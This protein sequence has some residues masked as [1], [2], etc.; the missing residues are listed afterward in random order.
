MSYLKGARIPF[1]TKYGESLAITN[2]VPLRDFLLEVIQVGL[3]KSP[4]TST[5]DFV[6]DGITNFATD[7]NIYL[8]AK[9]LEMLSVC[10]FS[11]REELRKVLTELIFQ[12]S[13]DHHLVDYNYNIEV[14][15]LFKVDYCSYVFHLISIKR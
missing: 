4:P 14:R 11:R 5:L 15:S 10:V 8:E 9:Q 1:L 6:K 3:R 12:G 13:V 7:Q 2:V